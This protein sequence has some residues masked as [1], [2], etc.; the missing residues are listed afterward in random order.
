MT[1]TYARRKFRADCVQG[2]A[3]CE[4]R[5]GPSRPGDRTWQQIGPSCGDQE[6]LV[7]NVGFKRPG[8]DQVR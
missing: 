1:R 2:E 8:T 3:V 6:S 5:V 7:V 4:M